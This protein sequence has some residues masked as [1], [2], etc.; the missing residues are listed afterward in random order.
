MQKT[1]N[2]S[3]IREQPETNLSKV[4]Q[5]FENGLK[6]TVLTAIELCSTIDL[7]KYVSMLR[8]DGMN[9]QSDWVQKGNKSY[10]VYYLLKE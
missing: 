3:R 10:K 4:K 8:K 7:R 5:C 1:D 6:L 2:L 9:I